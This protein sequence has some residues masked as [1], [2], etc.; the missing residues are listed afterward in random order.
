MISDRSHYNAINSKLL[1]AIKTR[2]NSAE[3]SLTYLGYNWYDRLPDEVR[4][5]ITIPRF[6]RHQAKYIKE[7][8]SI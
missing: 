5:E 2:T 7:T 6:K 8:I 3:Q 1:N 4:S